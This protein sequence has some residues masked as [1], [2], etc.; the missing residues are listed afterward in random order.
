MLSACR[1]DPGPLSL[2]FVTVM[3]MAYAG[4]AAMISSAAAMAADLVNGV[5]L[6]FLFI[7]RVNGSR[8]NR[9]TKR[10]FIFA[11]LAGRWL[12]WAGKE[13]LRGY[14]PEIRG[15]SDSL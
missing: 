8:R 4:P 11:F 13:E 7:V 10:T 15:Y 6:F 9:R 1:N 12:E 3:V 2:V 14:S 5:N